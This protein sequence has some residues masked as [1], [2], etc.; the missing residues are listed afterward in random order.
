MS[1]LN[2][3]KK[4]ATVYVDWNAFQDF[5]DFHSTHQFQQDVRKSNLEAKK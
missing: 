2:L 4:K 3:F 1:I 5:M